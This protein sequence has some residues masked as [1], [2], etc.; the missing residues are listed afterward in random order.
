VIRADSAIV[1]ERAPLAVYDFVAT[2]FFSNY[3]RWAPEVTQLTALSPGPLRV[4]SLGRQVRVD[5]GRRTEATFRVTR[6]MPGEEV[7]FEGLTTPFTIVYRFAAFGDHTRVALRFELARIE[8]FM[9]PFERVIR[10]AVD[11]SVVTT[12][13]KLKAVA[14]REIAPGTV[15]AADAAPQPAVPLP[16][17]GGAANDAAPPAGPAPRLD[18]DPGLSRA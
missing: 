8:F 15:G 4:G 12:M 1:I 14:E 7:A 11:E 10:R 2:G 3:P 17:S 13:R 5:Y 16:A 9:R 18:P 6:L